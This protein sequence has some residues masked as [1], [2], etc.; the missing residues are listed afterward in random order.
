MPDAHCMEGNGN[1]MEVIDKRGVSESLF[2]LLEMGQAF[3]YDGQF[4][5]KCGIGEVGT[6][7]V[8]L[9][10]GA[11]GQMRLD[12]AVEEVN[13]QVVIQDEGFEDMDF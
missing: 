1:D 12:Y 3:R 2:R 9:K 7:A 10:N 11:P 13:A 6:N 4:Y 8:N 5:I